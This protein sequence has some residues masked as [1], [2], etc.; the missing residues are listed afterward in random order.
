MAFKALGFKAL[1]L[2]SQVAVSVESASGMI[3]EYYK[4]VACQDAKTLLFGIAVWN[5]FS[6][7]PFYAFSQH[8][9]TL[10]LV[11]V[12]T[13]QIPVDG[14]LTVRLSRLTRCVRKC[15]HG[16]TGYWVK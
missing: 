13:G 10:G 7:A 9:P 1:L 16:S 14:L 4:L 6:E 8:G 5:Y 2:L 15:L 3:G 11:G 12:E